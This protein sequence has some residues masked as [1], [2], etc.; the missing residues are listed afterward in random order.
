M[1]IK[2]D[3]LYALNKAYGEEFP[4]AP[5]T[6]FQAIVNY[7]HHRLEQA[8][9]TL[10]ILER[11][12]CV[13]IVNRKPLARIRWWDAVPRMPEVSEIAKF[14]LDRPEDKLL[15]QRTMFPLTDNSPVS[16]YFETERI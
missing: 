2:V 12:K 15:I 3:I 6:L 14:D 11:G 10:E 7:N 9:P 4:L 13:R 8:A 16:Y 5:A 1:I